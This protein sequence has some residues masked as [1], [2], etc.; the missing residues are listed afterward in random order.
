MTFNVSVALRILGPR[1]RSIP[2]D[3]LAWGSFGI[4]GTERHEHN[5]PQTQG[6]SLE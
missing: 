4:L 6:L 5:L 2:V 1:R 3:C